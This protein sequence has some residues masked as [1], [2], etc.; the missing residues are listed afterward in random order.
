VLGL[1]VVGST[2]APAAEPESDSDRTPISWSSRSTRGQGG[3]RD[4]EKSGATGW[5]FGTAGIA[6]TL[7]ACGGISIAA[8]KY[9]PQSSS[10]LLRVIGRVSLSPRHSVYLLRVDGR[11]LLIGAGP[12]GA[13]SYLG[14]FPDASIDAGECGEF[15]PSTKQPASFRGLTASSAERQVRGEPV[16]RSAR[17]DVRLGD[18]E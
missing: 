17:L 1:L 3:N 13:P 2:T 15:L 16:G 4:A 9:L 18:E 6:L 5:W 14:E 12:Q 8:R 11:V 10:P 7:A